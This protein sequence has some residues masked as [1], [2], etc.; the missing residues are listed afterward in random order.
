MPDFLYVTRA[1]RLGMLT[2][3]PTASE[4]EA[5][6]RY[7]RYLVGPAERGQVLLAG[8]TLEEPAPEEP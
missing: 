7:F 4:A 6:E 8:R 1:T 3:G 5:I 2:E